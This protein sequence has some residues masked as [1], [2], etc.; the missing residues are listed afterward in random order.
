MLAMF[1]PTRAF[2]TCLGN[3]GS[4]FAEIF[5]LEQIFKVLKFGFQIII[6]AFFIIIIYLFWWWWW[7]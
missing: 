7:A 6:I 3:F 4:F 1:G 2:F 5:I